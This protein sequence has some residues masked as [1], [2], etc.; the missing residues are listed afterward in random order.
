MAYDYSCANWDGL[1]DHLTDVSWECFSTSAVA[2][3][4]YEWVQVGIDACIPYC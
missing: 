3:E 4:L 1:T 2:S